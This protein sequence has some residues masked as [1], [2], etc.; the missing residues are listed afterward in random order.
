MGTR[1]FLSAVLVAAVACGESLPDSHGSSGGNGDGS[2]SPQGAPA[3]PTTPS[4]SDP[5]PTAVN[6]A[7]TKGDAIC[8]SKD[9]RRSCIDNGAGG[10]RW[11]DESCGAGSGCVAGACVVG[12]CSDECTA[13]ETNA[14]GQTCKPY[15]LAS[16]TSA[17][18]A[19]GDK[20][21]DRARDYLSWMKRGAMMS[22]GIGS[23]RYEDPPSY[24]KVTSMDGIGDSAIWTGAFLGSEALRLTATG[25]PDAR[26]RVKSLA[27]TVHL[28]LNVAGEP[29]M[30]VR[31]AKE[32]ATTFPFT[33]GDY[34][35]TNERVHCGIDYQGKKYDVIGH[36]SRD[37]Y[38]G[39]MF[40]LALAYDALTSA[41]E[42]TRELLRK[43][44]VTIAK[45]L[46]KERTLPVDLSINGGVSIKTSVTGHYMVVS[47]REMKN[48]AIQLRV[49]TGK[50]DDSEM[51]GFQEFYPNLADLVRQ[52]PG[53]GWA[54]NIERASSAIMLTSFFRVAL[55]VTEGVPAYAKDRAELDAFYGQ[56]AGEWLAVA[57]KWKEGSGCGGDYYANNIAMM[58]LYNLARLET[59]ATVQSLVR[60]DILGDAMWP[61]FEKTKNVFFSFIYAGVTPNAP[62]TVV[63]T[64]STQ[65]AQFPVA[66]R[67]FVGTDLR[68][69][70]KY[71][72]RDQSCADQVGHEDAVDVGDRVVADFMWQRHP[73]GLYAG[74][75]VH[76]TQPGVDYLVA[77]FMG[78]A[79][80]FIEDDTAG[81]CLGWQ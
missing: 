63:T 4:S 39:I 43:D 61:V 1:A 33:I 26:A 10:T 80:G 81:S 9:A 34:D 59:N 5:A 6:D 46:M 27:E 71:P 13:G 7:C 50:M 67:V 58:P 74:G 55:H 8:T 25:A 22:G 51:F 47:P 18:L 56:H 45:E 32:S 41:D 21:H 54:P 79:H 77:Y 24:T 65:L 48:G 14:S 35:C 70:P 15:V 11:T 3:G 57:K 36:I 68:E 44:A 76:Q 37:Q 38:Q 53:L 30:L 69:S 42:P 16:K 19:P 62:S 49:N 31:W 40:G 2:S 66:P 72:S 64:A 12:K 60:D 75:D 52:M 20:L 29:G 23:A 17:T 73:W 28:W 78:R